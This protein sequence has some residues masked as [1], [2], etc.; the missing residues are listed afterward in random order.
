MTL[1]VSDTT[2]VPDTPDGDSTVNIDTDIQVDV[3]GL[4]EREIEPVRNV[5]EPVPDAGVKRFE[6]SGHAPQY[7][8][9]E[10]FNRELRWYVD[11]V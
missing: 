10:R 8:E 5:A 7:Q 1:C 3:Q 6:E 4:S 2:R 9:S 11:S